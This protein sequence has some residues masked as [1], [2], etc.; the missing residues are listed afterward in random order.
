MQLHLF[1]YYKYCCE[2]N[3]Q[4]PFETFFKK[5]PVPLIRVITLW[6]SI[7]CISLSLLSFPKKEICFF[8][9]KS[10]YLMY[11]CFKDLPSNVKKPVSIYVLKR[12]KT[13]LKSTELYWYLPI[14]AL[15]YRCMH[16]NYV[17]RFVFL[18]SGDWMSF[19]W[20]V[21]ISYIVIDFTIKLSQ[22]VINNPL[23]NLIY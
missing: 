20:K 10:A 14:T 18:W 8:K 2:V 12:W 3:C 22:C 15:Y 23:F 6:I 1:I 21:L 9:I 4:L 7:L 11:I 13:V 16:W 5:K 19:A 17:N